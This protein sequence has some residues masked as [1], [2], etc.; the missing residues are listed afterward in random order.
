M[1]KII[2]QLYWKIKHVPVTT[3]QQFYTHY[4]LVINIGLLIEE[5][6]IK[7]CDQEFSSHT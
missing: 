6:F 3:H 7:I 5:H 2:G 1:R 4:P